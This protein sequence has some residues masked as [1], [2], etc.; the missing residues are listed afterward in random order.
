MSRRHLRE[1]V[2]SLIGSYFDPEIKELEGINAEMDGRLQ[3]M[4]RCIKEEGSCTKDTITGFIGTLNSDYQSLYS[5][6][7]HLIEKLR[8][9]AEGKQGNCG[10]SPTSGS[11][12][13]DEAPINLP[14]KSPEHEKWG[15]ENSK[16]R[17][18]NVSLKLELV[19][20]RALHMEVTEAKNREI[21]RL[22]E[23][24]EEVKTELEMKD[25]E[26]SRLAD[27][28]R[29]IEI[30]QRLTNRKL[31]V[32]EQLLGEK[33][34]SHRV[35]VEKFLED[36][37]LLEER[38][39]AYEEARA[40]TSTEISDKVNETLMGMDN[41]SAKFQEDY[42][43]FESRVYDITNKLSVVLKCIDENNIEK[44]RMK[45]EI[46]D[47]VGQLKEK[48]ELETKLGSYGE[49]RKNLTRALEEREE[50]MA[51]MERRMKEK[52]ERILSMAEEKKEAI[53]QL[54]IWID[55]H[56]QR[57]RAA[58]MKTRGERGLIA[59]CFQSAF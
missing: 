35:R 45:N 51:E 1:S 37:K 40:K 3:S 33:E 59:A 5:R 27:N 44:D 56:H 57:D 29:A 25:D 8:K 12:D 26:I 50:K 2:E 6:Y 48:E 30:S 17:M 54:C 58:A 39:S 55:D 43:H 52:D 36:H 11:S 15:K 41:L 23:N 18:E 19:K 20:L 53:R 21:N 9:K 7:D 24:V 14:A 42:K 22:E 28:L 34:E 16:L 49:E 10:S 13:S 47:L 38:I 46:S 4:L 31:L 32:T